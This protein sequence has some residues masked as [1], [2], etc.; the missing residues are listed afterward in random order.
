MTRIGFGQE[1][2]QIVEQDFHLEEALVNE[3][4]FAL[5]NGYLGMR[6]TFEEGL[7]RSGLEG[8]Y[9]NGF[10]ESAPI[11]YGEKFQ[12]FAE[13]K[14][15]I[16]NLANAKVIR[17]WIGDGGA[18]NPGGGGGTGEEFNLLTGKILSYQ[19][20]LNMR[21]GVLRRIMVWQSPQGKQVQ[22]AVERLVLHTHQ[23]TAM[24]RYQL[25]PLN[26]DGPI[27][28]FSGIDGA[29]RQSEHAEDDP[30]LGTVFAGDVL[31]LEEQTFHGEVALMVHRTVTTRFSVAC[32]I[33][34][35]LDTSSACE[36]Y[37]DGQSIG[38]V[39]KLEAR[40]GLPVTLDKYM[41]YATS[42]DT[43]AGTIAPT[44]LSELD[45]A[46]ATGFDA[47]RTEQVNYLANFWNAADIIIDGDDVLQCGIRFNMFHLLQSAGRDGRTNI[48][49][50]GLTGLGYEG[51]YFWD[52]E[53]YI[54]PFF[55]YTQPE[56][57]RKLVEYRYHILDKARQRAREMSHPHGALYPWRT[58]NGEECSANF[59]TGTAQ[60]HINADIALAIQRYYDATEDEDFMKLYG[61]EILCETARLWLDVGDYIDTHGHRF[62]INGVT[63]PDE[64]QILVNNNAYTNL[65][66]RENLRFAYQ[67]VTW[68]RQTDIA[69]YEALVQ[70]ISLRVDE[71][72]A[73]QE[74]AEKM[75]IPY[76]EERRII[77][78]DDAFLSKAIWD[79]EHTPRENYPL[80]LHYHPLVV[81]RY[82]VC[83]QADLVLA[84]FL[85]HDQFDHAQK[86][87]DYNYYEP[88]TTHDSSLSGAIFGIVAAELGDTE[89]A[90]RY[91]A[92]TA[93]M[94]LENKHGNTR[95]GI[96]AANMA[97][98]W[99]GI[100]FGFAGMRAKAGLSFNP[101]IPEHWHAYAFKIR[102]RGRLIGVRVTPDE[103]I[104]ELLTGES[105]EIRVGDRSI[106]LNNVS[107]IPI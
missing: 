15:T 94:D 79:F 22:L 37:N 102:Y 62:C 101:T 41:V 82:Q 16:L 46:V 12:G 50:K 64:Y 1:D 35:V 107:Q 71:P 100:I 96:H 6:G 42:R 33:R 103:A 70:K 3:T 47:L 51:H 30:R 72:A 43:Q 68:L 13:N 85:L 2:W 45:T 17:L 99:Q 69:A 20:A 52:T 66:A 91:F 23:H 56:I 83:K 19:R 54:L 98:A 26:F 75:Y 14:Q 61:T 59:P 80:L 93:T 57:S 40:R 55:L 25:T 21:E 78:Q 44:V 84:E 32:G 48:A 24:I 29:I 34:N 92:D 38:F 11:I 95:A 73:W 104:F 27:T 90:Y 5:G 7:G 67:I 97:G 77:P 76:D 65:M 89:K 81:T 105:L 74:A 18:N 60:Y 28:L 86:L 106:Q 58:I 9:I 36:L 39:Y 87:R 88:L 63:G 8:T 10:F 53:I 4:L 49:A 31:K